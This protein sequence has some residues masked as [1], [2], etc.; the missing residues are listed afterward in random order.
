ELHSRTYLDVTNCSS[1]GCRADGK[2]VDA[3]YRMPVCRYG[4]PAYKIRVVLQRARKINFE[5]AAARRVRKQVMLFPTGRNQ[6]D[7]QW[8]HRL[9]ESQHQ[10]LWHLR[11]HRTVRR[12]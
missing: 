4:A 1:I 2:A 7:G 12:F 6:P 5:L 10:A 3:A 11:E 9:I 8:R